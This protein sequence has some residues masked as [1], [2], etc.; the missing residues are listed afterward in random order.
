MIN[1]QQP[2]ILGP[3]HPIQIIARLSA[4]PSNQTFESSASLPLQHSCNQEVPRTIDPRLL[5]QVTSV[6][7]QTI[8]QTAHCLQEG[9]VLSIS[10]GSAAVNNCSRVRETPLEPPRKRR[11]IRQQAQVDHLLEGIN[12]RSK[13]EN[14]NAGRLDIEN[15]KLAPLTT[16]GCNLSDILAALDATEVCLDS[17]SLARRILLVQLVEIHDSTTET[18]QRAR[19]DA[20]TPVSLGI[21]G[22]AGA[23]WD[24]MVMEANPAA[25]KEIESLPRSQWRKKYK[26]ERKRIKNRHQVGKVW[27]QA[28]WQFSPGIL[29]LFPRGDHQ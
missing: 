11:K 4:A 15:I 28:F 17:L 8:Y 22:I 24:T 19:D 29:V 6:P 10:Q 27:H 14:L 1:V 5:L 3:Q 7:P 21:G 23:T 18:I 2:L 16:K 9:G 26:S 25:A 12:I 13:E 20:E